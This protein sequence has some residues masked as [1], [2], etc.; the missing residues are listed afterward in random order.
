[1][2][3]F[4]LIMQLLAYDDLPNNSNPLLAGINRRPSLINIPCDNPQTLKFDL[5]AGLTVTS[6]NGTRTLGVDG[7]T[8]FSLTL[9]PAN[10]STY[11]L[12]NTGG[13]APV[14]RTARTVPVSSVVLTLAVGANLAMTIT[15][16]T[17]TPFSTVQVGDTLLIPGVSTGDPA[18][19][20]NALNEGLWYVLTTSNTI[21][22][23]S[24]DPSGVFSGISEVVTPAANA[25]FLVYSSDNV[26]IGDTIGLSAGFATSALHSYNV[27][28]V[29]SN[30][31]EFSSSTPLG[32][33]TGIIPTATGLAIYTNAKRFVYIESDQ[34][35]V[36][37][38]NGDSSLVN[39]ITPLIAGVQFQEGTFH[40]WGSV[41]Q[42]VLINKSSNI[43]HL[44]ICT[45]E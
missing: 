16:A 5:G 6:F 18:S 21:L 10:P 23:V 25:Q 40:K 34:E 42:L 19:P 29:T 26:Q 37:Q 27:T 15:A 2:S 32:N 35:I 12:L 3:K 13:T 38:L 36:Y 9:S 4:T 1:M 7:T 14:F 33:Q 39:K 8:A 20:F 43:A 11:R 44:T 28:N 22:T 41:W 24:R 17:G 30:W 31:V 45:V